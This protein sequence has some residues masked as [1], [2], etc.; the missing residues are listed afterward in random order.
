MFGSSAE[1]MGGIAGRGDALLGAVECQKC[2]GGLHPHF[3]F[4]G[5]R[6]HQF[7]TLHDIADKLKAGCVKANELKEFLHIQTLKNT[8]VA[9]RRLKHNGHALMNR[10]KRSSRTREM[11]Q[12][13]VLCRTL[14][15][16]QKPY[17]GVRYNK[18]RFHR[19]W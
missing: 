16:F 10:V 7:H 11:L 3:F 8:T 6:L 5:Q 12:K 4:F 18:A 1:L 2:S 14:E 17:N 13:K 15:A 19:S 9:R